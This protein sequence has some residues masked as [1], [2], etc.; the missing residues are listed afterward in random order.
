M[1]RKYALGRVQY[2]PHIGLWCC[3]YI[4]LNDG[5]EKD[6]FQKPP[7]KNVIIARKVRNS[8]LQVVVVKARHRRPDHRHRNEISPL[9]RAGRWRRRKPR[10][11]KTSHIIV[12]AF[13]NSQFAIIYNRSPRNRNQLDNQQ[14]QEASTMAQKAVTSHAARAEILQSTIRTPAQPYDLI[15]KSDNIPGDPRLRGLTGYPAQLNGPHAV[16]ADRNMSAIARLRCS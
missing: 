16:W 9:C 13:H 2:T 11:R 7:L 12:D 4:Y 10:H 14:H 15:N 6:T 8:L 3:Q 1:N 5:S